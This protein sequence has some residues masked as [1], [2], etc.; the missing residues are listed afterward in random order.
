MIVDAS[1]EDAFSVSRRPGDPV[2]GSGEGSKRSFESVGV[3]PAGHQ[4]CSF[5]PTPP[6][7]SERVVNKMVTGLITRTDPEERG[8]VQ[9]AYWE[10]VLK[11]DRL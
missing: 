3:L 7:V 1:N 9:R 6:H 2:I 8:E 10:E 11:D 5:G 4:R